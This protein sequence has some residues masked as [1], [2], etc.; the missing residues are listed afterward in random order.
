MV[1]IKLYP[2]TLE[3]YLDSD[4]KLDP[5]NYVYLHGKLEEIN[6]YDITYFENEDDIKALLNKESNVKVVMKDGSEYD[7]IA[8]VWEGFLGNIHMI[9]GLVCAVDD[10][11]YI[12]DAR[13]KFNKREMML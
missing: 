7:A 1:I 6:G 9:R 12:E 3:G 8:F 10:N 5:F 4:D 2:D 11:T 13:I